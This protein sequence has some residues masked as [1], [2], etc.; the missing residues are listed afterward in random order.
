MSSSTVSF[1]PSLE[2]AARCFAG[3]HFIDETLV[4]LQAIVDRDLD[5]LLGAGDEDFA[6]IDID[7]TAWTAWADPSPSGNLVS[8]VLPDARRPRCIDHL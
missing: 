4:L 3:E 8:S 2:L 1:S 5:G 6:V 7:P